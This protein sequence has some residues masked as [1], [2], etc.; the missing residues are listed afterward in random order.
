MKPAEHV[1]L[2][3]LHDAHEQA[4]RFLFLINVAYLKTRGSKQEKGA[5]AEKCKAKNAAKEAR[6]ALADAAREVLGLDHSVLFPDVLAR[7]QE[8]IAATSDNADKP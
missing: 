4:D 3:D 8:A 1:R 7:T 5:H 2:R 6:K